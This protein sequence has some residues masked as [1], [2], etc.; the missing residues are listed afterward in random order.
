MEGTLVRL[1]R[2]ELGLSTQA[3]AEKAGAG[4]NPATIWRIE[5]GLTTRPR[6][7]TLTCLFQA[8]LS[9]FDTPGR[10]PSLTRRELGAAASRL[11]IT[12]PA[13]TGVYDGAKQGIS[14]STK[15]LPALSQGLSPRWQKLLGFDGEITLEKARGQQLFLRWSTYQGAAEEVIE[16][17]Q[18]AVEQ[19][20][21]AEWAKRRGDKLS[22]EGVEA[23]VLL[24]VEQ[25]FAM[26]ETFPPTEYKNA[27]A[28][29][30][31]ARSLAE[32]GQLRTW[33]RRQLLGSAN[34]ALWAIA[35]ILEEE[36]KRGGAGSLPGLYQ[37]CTQGYGQRH[38]LD[39]ALETDVLIDRIWARSERMKRFAL[40]EDWSAMERDFAA[41]GREME[42]LDIQ[43]GGGPLE[44]SFL[45]FESYARVLGRRGNATGEATSA[46]VEAKRLALL[47]TSCYQTELTQAE[48][49]LRSG[50]S[51]L[52]RTG[53]EQLHDLVHR[54]ATSNHQWQKTC[55]LAEQFSVPVPLGVRS[56]EKRRAC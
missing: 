45:L 20:K 5:A 12:L 51:T 28:A 36:M 56:P 25:V 30:R 2:E 7:S 55:W 3:L 52:I 50:K 39:E 1:A 38:P 49:N 44:L 40:Q 31:T 21:S 53:Q 33:K 13:T 26:I 37:S 22:P 32:N 24:Y 34:L 46:L 48:L 9:E 8:L 54:P 19:V 42:S 47:K 14:V 6:L 4:I 29:A 41:A 18:D 10:E 11:G 23:Q 15:S 35:R 27:I 16:F 43:T 17:C